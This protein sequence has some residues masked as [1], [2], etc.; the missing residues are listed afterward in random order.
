MTVLTKTRMNA[1][2]MMTGILVCISRRNV[3]SIYH[4]SE[5]LNRAFYAAS[6]HLVEVA[7]NLGLDVRFAAV[8]ESDRVLPAALY[9]L[10]ASGLLTYSGG[11]L[12]LSTRRLALVDLTNLPGT[13]ELYTELG[14]IFLSAY[15]A[16]PQAEPA[17]TTLPTR[18]SIR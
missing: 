11:D 7:E 4:S 16:R 8:A 15:N 2:D 18:P 3:T 14:Q 5:S 12:Y 1:T 9:A 10:T 17:K 6:L 13:P